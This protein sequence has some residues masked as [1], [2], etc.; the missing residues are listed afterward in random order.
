M[1]PLFFP[2]LKG[3]PLAW[4][5]TVSDTYAELHIADTV[6]TPGT[7]AH[8]AAQNKIAK[9]SKLASTHVTYVL[10]MP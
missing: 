3:K 9:F 6:S 1:A 10:P 7:A 8:Q 5:V 4:D 2:G